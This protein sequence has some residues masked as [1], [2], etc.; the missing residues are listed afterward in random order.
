MAITKH[1]PLCDS[2][3][4]LLDVSAKWSVFSQ[5]WELT[6]IDSDTHGMCHDCE[7]TFREHEFV[8]QTT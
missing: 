7:N 6:V 8:E 2:D 4:I 1:C 5:C 3:N